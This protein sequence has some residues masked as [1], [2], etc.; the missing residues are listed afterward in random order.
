MLFS[1]D[2]IERTLEAVA[3]L[4]FCNS[5]FNLFISI[6]KIKSK[7]FSNPLSCKAQTKT[8]L[9]KSLSQFL[10]KCN[11]MKNPAASSGVDP[12]SNQ[13]ARFTMGASIYFIRSGVFFRTLRR[14]KGY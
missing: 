8:N 10:N 1:N 11:S 13:Q 2:L 6:N 4:Q 12:P 14:N 3:K 9:D 7:K 5:L